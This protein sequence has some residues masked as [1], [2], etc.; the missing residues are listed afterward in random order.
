MVFGRARDA[1]EDACRQGSRC[2]W[3]E[4]P[5]DPARSAEPPARARPRIEQAA[6]SRPPAPRRRGRGAR[7]PRPQA[8]RTPAATLRLLA[9][10]PHGRSTRRCA[11]PTS[12]PRSTPTCATRTLAVP[13]GDLPPALLDEHRA[14]LGA[15]AAV[16]AAL[17]QRRDQRDR[18]NVNW[19]RAR[20]GT[21][22]AALARP[23]AR[24]A[25]LRLRR[26]STTPSSCSSAA[27]ATSGTRSRCSS[28]RPG[29]PTPSSTATCATSTATTPALMEPWDGPAAIVFTDGR[30]VGAALDR[31]G[32][33]P[34]RYVV[35]R[36]ASSAARPRPACSTL[37][38]AR[39]VRRGRLGPGRDARRR[40]ASAA[41][42]RTR[43]SSGGSPRR[44]PY[45]SWLADWRRR[46][47][48][49]SP[50]PAPTSEL[51]R[52]RSLFGYTREELT[53]V[54][55][56]TAAHGARADL[57]DGGRH[58]AA[59]AGRPRAPAVQLLPAAVRAG[60]EP[61][62]RPPARAVRDVARHAARRARAAARARRP[63][64][65]RASSSRASSSS[66]S[67]L[68]RA[69]GRAPGRDVRRRTRASARRA[70]G[71][72]TR[73][74]RPSAR[75]HGILLLTDAA[76]APDRPPVPM[77]L[78][79]V[80]V[81]HRLVAP[82]CARSR[83][84]S[85][86]ATSR[87]RCTTSPACS[88]SARRRSAR[89]SRSRPSP[90]WPRRTGSAAT[91]LARGGAAALPAGDRGRRAQGDVEDGHLRRGELLRRADLRRPRPRA[92]A[93]RDV[94]PRH[95]GP[96]GGIGLAELEQEAVARA[97]AAAGDKP[98]LENPGYVKFRKGGEPHA[99]NPD[100]VD[101]LQRDALAAH[102]LRRAVNGDGWQRLRALRRA[103]QRPR[104]DRAARPARA[105]AGR[106]PVPLEEVE[107]AE[108]IVARF[109]S[110]GMSHGALSAEAHETIAL[111][112][113]RLGARSNCGE[114]G[115]E[116]GAVP[117][118]SATPGSSRSR[119][120]ASE[121][122][123]ST[124]PSPTSSRSR[125]RRARS[126]ARAASSPATRSRRRSRACATRSPASR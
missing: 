33:R 119:R 11:P 92:R 38:R 1:V 31:N 84:S 99:T 36:T 50:S 116:P 109:S 79:V 87:A 16:P 78:A 42:R 124:R 6:R 5:V 29:R 111:A 41:S 20:A 37:P 18:G 94:L 22:G 85:S 47:R 123:R 91:P 12:S 65:P 93:R 102:A 45:G 53:V 122:R 103:R 48:A 81:H 21:I 57:L 25:E 106:E 66:P 44:R 76:A 35:A 69:R 19:M 68:E 100:V 58:G 51:T 2:G 98:Q 8:A 95:A 60:H 88:A 17:P 86:R 63:R 10:V 112:F 114:G 23:A 83:R 15:R 73:P 61:G 52:A 14:D 32:L 71:S 67:A 55:R 72:L 46:S 120:R 39:R 27:A 113:N 108:A 62:D 26:C 90:R 118:P 75:A 89:G 96:V 70:R 30:A 49:A 125:S 105:R 121:S 34:L 97:A 74:R 56:P 4:V 43:R 80:A 107:P 7:V 110:G 117:R 104:A 115:E 82:A 40:P 64:P 28:R 13:F 24:R 54:L 3:R 9:L 77:L 126:P 101:A 59:A